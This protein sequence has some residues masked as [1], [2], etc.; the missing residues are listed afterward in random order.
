L[1]ERI[2]DLSQQ[3]ERGMTNNQKRTIAVVEFA[4]LNGKVTNFGRFLAEE[5]ITN[6]Y[7]KRFKVIERQLLNRV[8][9]EQK[10]SL[11]G[12]V[13]QSTA[14]RLGKILGVD[15]IAS[16]TVTDLG[17]NLRVNAR[18]ISTETGEVFAVAST[19]VVKDDEVSNLTGGM[20]QPSGGNAPSVPPPGDSQSRPVLR[21]SVTQKFEANFFTIELLR[22][23]I[24][25]PNVMCDLQITNNGDDRR[26]G[27]PNDS[28][29]VDDA[30]NEYRRNSTQIAN[31][32]GY[33]SIL[34]VS[35]VTMAARVAF[36]EVS[37]Q[38]RKISLLTLSFSIRNGNSFGSDHFNVQFRNIPLNG[39]VAAAESDE[40]IDVGRSNLTRAEESSSVTSTDTVPSVSTGGQQTFHVYA[41]RQ[42]TDTGIDVV[43]GMRLEVTA[44][45]SITSSGV[46]R[47]EAVARSVLNDILK[48]KTSSPPRQPARQIVGPSALFAKIRYSKGGDS[49][50]LVVGGRNTLVVEQGEFGRLYFGIDSR[51]LRDASGSFSVTVKW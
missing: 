37:P 33:N 31:T 32:P 10:L 49:N 13:D 35:G 2:E 8:I 29:M 25:G 27:F 50:S 15:A 40:D 19:T 45:G 42:W 46:S 11:S 12:A 21:K 30:G 36:D 6:L 24:S 1:T 43:P 41:D 23:R 26:L 44:S 51:Y 18:L 48:G 4:D 14:Q 17:R 5:L 47:T 34:S 3:I 16:G 20:A 39:A 22:C 9:A 7:Q 28:I 38:A